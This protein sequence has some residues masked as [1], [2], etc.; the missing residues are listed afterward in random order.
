[1]LSFCDFQISHRKMMQCLRAKEKKTIPCSVEIPVASLDRDQKKTQQIC[2]PRGDVL[3][4]Q[5]NFISVIFPVIPCPISRVLYS[6]C[7]VMLQHL[8]F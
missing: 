5:R 8:S 3:S 4:I 1:M 7:R 6:T 2:G